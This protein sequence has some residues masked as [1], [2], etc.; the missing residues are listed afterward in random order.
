MY[1]ELCFALT[2]RNCLRKANYIFD[3]YFSLQSVTLDCEYVVVS[4]YQCSDMLEAPKEDNIMIFSYFV[5]KDRLFYRRI[6][7]NNCLPFPIRAIN[8]E[9]LI[10]S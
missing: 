5:S 7:E 3:W 8:L 9:S 10:S 6:R 4:N 2:W 1:R